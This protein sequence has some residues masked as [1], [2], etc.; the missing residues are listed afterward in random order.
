[1]SRF[2]TEPRSEPWL[3]AGFILILLL[4][5]V[6]LDSGH[7]QSLPDAP[8]A[9]YATDRY[10]HALFTLEASALAA[11]VIQDG[12]SAT[13]ER[14]SSMGVEASHTS[15]RKYTAIHGGI[16]VIVTIAAWRLERSPRKPV[17]LIGHS[18]VWAAVGYH[19]G[20]YFSRREN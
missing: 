19:A 1:M 10:P 18:L 7:C 13:S 20:S 8:S 5:S 12:R 15:S 3:L 2:R 11:A 14:Y 9:T 16:A 4:A 6:L 17:R